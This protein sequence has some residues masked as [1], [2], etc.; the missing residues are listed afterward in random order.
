MANISM[1]LTCRKRW[2]FGAAYVVAVIALRMGLVR[3]VA[4][5]A[6]SDGVKPASER[7]AQ[8][9]VRNCMVLT[10]H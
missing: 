6:Y 3:D 10:F 5:A 2:F 1:T 4:D 7:V 8:W 9:L